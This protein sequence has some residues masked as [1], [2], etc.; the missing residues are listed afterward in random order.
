[1]GTQHLKPYTSS[2]DTHPANSHHPPTLTTHCGRPDKPPLKPDE[3]AQFAPRKYHTL[4]RIRGWGHPTSRRRT[5]VKITRP[6]PDATPC[7]PPSLPQCTPRRHHVQTS[8]G[9]TVDHRKAI[10]I[11][12][13]QE[14][15]FK[16]KLKGPRRGYHCH[17]HLIS[18]CERGTP[19]SLI[20]T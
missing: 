19:P 5:G 3:T 11:S 1:M 9:K 16:T 2:I 14:E 20:P 13:T 12:T 15:W 7:H 10:K 6:L 18:S 17:T 4:T 8:E